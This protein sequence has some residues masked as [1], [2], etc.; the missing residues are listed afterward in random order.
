MHNATI[1]PARVSDHYAMASICSA[2]FFEE[3]LFGRIIHPKRHEYPDDVALFW[4]QFI[5]EQWFDWR[6]KLYV[7]VSTGDEK[8]AG[9]EIVGVAVWQRQGKV[10][11]GMKLRAWDPRNIIHPLLT[12]HHT[13]LQPTLWPNRAL[14]P[15]K[16]TL[17][18]SAEPF[19]A[20][21]WAGARSE[22]WYL[23]LLATSPAAQG[24]GIGKRLV[25]LGLDL[26]REEGVHASV[27]SSEGN[28][29]FYLKSGFD[30]VVGWANE[31]EENPLRK[32]GVKGGAIL[33]MFP[34]GQGGRE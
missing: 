19:V 30:E 21:H 15:T 18:P 9:D 4:L 8:S 11:D 22:N 20:H 13:L 24:R 6:N 3:D 34:E 12:L 2:A 25:K 29:V 31:G 17:L 27:M 10:G 26:A 23:S 1:R 33:F 32:E 16:T 14:D 7:A 28:D 5:R